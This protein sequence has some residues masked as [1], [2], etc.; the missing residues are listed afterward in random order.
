MK[1]KGIIKYLGLTLFFVLFVFVGKVSASSFSD[2]KFDDVTFIE[3]GNQN[4]EQ[5]KESD[6]TITDCDN[7]TIEIINPIEVS[8]LGS[9][10]VLYNI[11]NSSNEIV[12]TLI[13][14]FYVYNNAN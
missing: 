12:E 2:A 4:Y 5:P 7:C 3:V 8:V 14:D 10:E 6:V 1:S 13:R 9:Y 11:K